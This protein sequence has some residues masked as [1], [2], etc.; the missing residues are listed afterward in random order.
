MGFARHIL[1]ARMLGVEDYGIAV[2][3]AVSA[4]L[5]EMASTFG[6]QKLIVQAREGDDPAW[7]AALQGFHLLRGVL[8]AAV[9]FALAKPIATFFGVSN[10]VWAYQVLAL[11]PLLLGFEHFDIHRLTRR[12]L[13][14]PIMMY[15]VLPLT[16]SVA[17]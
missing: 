2:T 13:Y 1:V 14:R 11:A 4:A 8:A 15:R 3:F 7:Q 6:L 5:V 16:V 17:A 10:L 9:L 12:K